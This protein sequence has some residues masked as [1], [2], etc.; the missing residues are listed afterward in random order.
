[1]S[2]KWHRSRAWDDEHLTGALWPVKVVLRVFSSIPLAVFLLSLV[3]IYGALASVPIGLIASIPTYMIYAVTLLGVIG[4]VAV[5]PAWLLWRGLSRRGA[6]RFVLSL[7]ALLALV[8]VAVWLWVGAF[9]PALHYDPAT[10][11]GLMLFADFIER[12]RATTLRRLP[13]MEMSE[14]EFYAWWPL[15]VVLLA[16]VANLATATVRRIEFT[17]KHTG[18]LMVHTGIIVIALGSIY[19]AGLKKEGDTLLVSGPPMRETGR[20]GLGTPQRAFYDNT[21]LSLYVDQGMG[22]EQ[23]PLTNVPR[24]NDYN[25]GAIDGESAWAMSGRP[26]PWDVPGQQGALSIKVPGSTLGRVDDAVGLRVVGYATYATGVPDVVRLDPA[27][28]VAVSADSPGL[29]PLRIVTLHSDLPDDKGVVSDAPAFMFH[30]APRSPADRMTGNES[31]SIEYTQG[32]SESR[33]ASLAQP[34]PDNARHALVFEVMDASGA[35]TY[36]GVYQAVAGASVDVGDT[37]WRVSVKSVSP[38]PPF[39]I[40]T[41]GYE[42]STSSVAVVEVTGP[43][44]ERFERWVYHRFPEIAQDLVPGEGEARPVRKA[45]DPKVRISLIEADHL[46]VYL[47]E[48]PDGKVRAIVREPRGKV[49]VESEI[50]TDGWLRDIVPQV[51]LKLGAKWDHAAKVERP[52]PVPVPERD[53]RMVGT[54]DK[55]MLGVEV[56]YAGTPM[57]RIVWLPFTKYMGAGFGTERSVELPDGKRLT[58]AFGRRQHVFPGFDLR[59]VDFEMVAYDHRGSPRDYQSLVK[60]TP[61]EGSEFPEYVHT[62]KLNEPLRAPFHWRDDKPWLWNAWKRLT[63]GL[64]PHQFKLSQAGWDANGWERTQKMADAGEL[65]GPYVQ[66]TILGVGNNPGIHII[67]LGSILFSV[68]I[69]WAFYL[70]PWLVQREKRKIQEALKAG[71]YQRPAGA[72]QPELQEARS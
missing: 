29:N 56:T 4:V 37:G 16:F 70:K 6:V 2:A 35:A 1:M 42:G 54:H 11:R 61:R 31:F 71:T 32:M 3:A 10:G 67:A 33:W 7:T 45:A 14:L 38:E 57:R 28:A 66:F 27:A 60:V 53:G 17:F 47:D 62:T 59:L 36:T 39:P 69:P 46:A 12:T 51:S 15:R 23:R 30:L 72:Y 41:K 18:V 8:P 52:S 68:G 22:W 19:Y 5:I 43:A 49:R 9:W 63:A 58:L 48:K 20:P 21:R 50:D 34:I 64:S 13:I 25:L 26:G 65:P 40:I 24:Y 55:A 44:G